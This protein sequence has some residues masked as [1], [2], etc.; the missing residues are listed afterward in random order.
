MATR[1]STALSEM[2]LWKLCICIISCLHLFKIYCHA[3]EFNQEIE[4]RI[5]ERLDFFLNGPTSSTRVIRNYQENG[6]FSFGNIE[7]SDRNQF[8]KLA[9][10]VPEPLVYIGKEDG[11]CTGYYWSNGYYREPGNS[12][13]RIANFNNSSSTSSSNSM[14]KHLESCVD[15]DTGEPAQCLME[16][17]KEYDVV[18]CKRTGTPNDLLEE[19][20]GLC[21][22]LELCSNQEPCNTNL[23]AEEY[24]D[25]KS[26]LKWCRQYTIETITPSLENPLGYIPITNMCIDAQG[27]FSQIF[28]G[29]ISQQDGNRLAIASHELTTCISGNGNPIQR[30]T[31]GDYAACGNTMESNPPDMDPNSGSSVVCDNVFVGGYSSSEYDPRYRPWYISTKEKQA[32]LWTE[33]YPFFTLGIGI[34]YAEPIYSQHNEKTVFAGVLAVDYRFDDIANFLIQNYGNTSTAVAIYEVAEPNYLIA[35]STG[36][37]SAN[38]VLKSDTSQPCP[39]NLLDRG[40]D[41][42]P[43]EPVRIPIL[44]LHGEYMDRAL[45]KA[46]KKHQ[47]EGYPNDRL[48]SFNVENHNDD[49]ESMNDSGFYASHSTIYSKPEPGLSWRIVVVSPGETSS[50][51]VL[52]VGQETFTVVCLLASLGVAICSFFFWVIYSKRQTREVVNCDWR[53]TCAFIF[54]C[55]ILNASTF[56][57]LGKNNRLMC[58]LR[59][60]SFHLSFVVALSPLFV[61]TWRIWKLVGQTHIIRKKAISNR[62][63]IAYTMPMIFF[64]ACILL[65][66]TFVDPPLGVEV[67]E[68]EGNTVSK[69]IDC[70]R[71]TPAFLSVVVLYE[72]GLVLAGCALA[73]LTRNMEDDYGESK[74]LIFSMYNLALV[75]FVILIVSQITYW[76]PNGYK[77]L[78]AVGVFWGTTFSASAFVI[79]R[80]IQIKERVAAFGT[81]GSSNSSRHSRGRTFSLEIRERKALLA[82]MPTHAEVL[83]EPEVK[84]RSRSLSPRSESMKKRSVYFGDENDT[85][86]RKSS[87]IVSSK[88]EQ[89][90]TT[91]DRA[92]SQL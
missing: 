88:E 29:V 35:T 34:T 76:D 53:F 68:L 74:Q 38:F 65:I 50:N 84:R 92:L 52:S 70:K 48:I 31:T 9:Y 7:A 37:T 89:T 15:G 75:A 64:Q 11:L 6:G 49:D 23:L 47:V 82:Q 59:M 86:V 16:T 79:P 44:E 36:S 51:D 67:I 66:F 83:E 87:N 13:Y 1:G 45:A 3:A 4:K 85:N 69:S 40:G 42:V 28:Q 19:E 46:A 63:A 5:L 10:G 54:G 17:G 80:L 18:A 56:F 32:P 2:H 55:I 60:W 71:E 21:Q 72:T 61:K 27:Q 78:Q 14:K 39:Q 77:V 73:F 26:K 33:P 30:N 91:I 58:T 24:E 20:S 62:T 8:L 57:L 43:C 90:S 12:G 41:D 81:R 22:E 25:C